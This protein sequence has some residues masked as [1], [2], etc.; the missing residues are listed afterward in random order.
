[1]AKGRLPKKIGKYLVTGVIGSGAQ[2]VVLGGID[3]VLKR[4]VAIKVL[5][6]NSTKVQANRLIAEARIASRLRH[7]NVVTLLD[8]GLIGSRPY[9]VFEL[10]KGV[11]LL[12]ELK[13]NG[14]LGVQRGV[15]LMSQIL[16]GVATAHE[17]A[18]S[19]G[20]LSTR[21]IIFTDNDLP[22][23]MDFGLSSVLRSEATTSGVIAGTPRYMSPELLRKQ[24]I[25]L[26]SD[27]FAL[28]AIFYEM[29]TG[30]PQFIGNNQKE[31]FKSIVKAPTR[32][33]SEKNP[34]VPSILDDVVTGALARDPA[35][36]F[37]NAGKMKELLDEYRIP[38]SKSKTDRHSTV[39]FMLRR[40]KHSPGF[41]ALSGRISDVLKLTAIDG[42]G[43]SRQLANMLA[44]DVTLA[45]RVLTMANSA[46]YGNTEITTLTH[47]IGWMGL[48]KVRHCVT[49]SLL[50]SQFSKGTPELRVA[51]VKAFCSGLL[52]KE[53]LASQRLRGKEDAFLAGMF[54]SL[55][56]MLVMHYFPDE[57]A[58]IQQAV[59]EG[60]SEFSVCRK[61]I[62]LPYHEVGQQVGRYWKLPEHFIQSMTPLPRGRGRDQ[63]QEEEEEDAV[64]NSQLLIT[65]V[66]GLSNAIV[67]VLMLDE[68]SA[69][70]YIGKFL[71]RVD[72][73]IQIAPEG[74]PPLLD[75]VVEVAR[76]YASM[77]GATEDA[78]E[79]FNSMESVIESGLDMTTNELFEG[80]DDRS[81][82]L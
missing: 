25:G 39:E 32:L 69:R 46:M 71:D 24:P 74:V 52:S 65:R 64:D 2:G 35:M 81:T 45:Q 66:A 43:D 9:L 28:G 37:P 33:P 34:D 44:K 29:L 23:V 48:K 30:E 59:T 42:M 47:A 22:K 75:S 31:L 62:G 8:F 38:R 27:V 5:R 79:F 6:A 11:S 63:E 54:H 7:P 10:L 77:I 56:K 17:E 40:F 26:Q 60:N 80:S 13:T 55:G 82:S 12:E 16:G 3:Q 36:R 18:I 76:K 72:N 21:N 19:H 51:Q 50:Q 58:T 70:E 61:V 78:V 49:S 14:A 73:I 20:D 15:I 41:S 57:F 1:V 4:N 67:D 53:I 68:F